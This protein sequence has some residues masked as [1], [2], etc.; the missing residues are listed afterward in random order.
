MVRM[1]AVALAA[2]SVV[3]LSGC[4]PT[5]SAPPGGS[6]EEN[7]ALVR[8]VQ[9]DAQWTNLDL[10]AEQ[11]PA[12]VGYE[13]VAID[14]W[15][16][17]VAACMTAK[18]YRN[19]EARGGNLQIG[20]SATFSE[21]VS[22]AIDFFECRSAFQRE[23]S[24]AS[25]I[26]AEQRE[27]LYDYYQESLVPCLELAGV[28]VESAPTRAAFAATGEGIGWNPY[29]ALDGFSFGEVSVDAETLER[30][31]S[32]PKDAVFDPWRLESSG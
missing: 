30:C 19:F 2:A 14:E 22:E 7:L 12:D 29:L 32:F 3:L 1:A 28:R 13:V 10:P 24:I 18:G 6:A 5:T 27:Y 8:E 4:V 26:N 20:K 16:E 25:G 11:R 21:E 15:A 9:L 31:P 17:R 23:L